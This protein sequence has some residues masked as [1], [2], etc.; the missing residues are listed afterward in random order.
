MNLQAK[1]ILITGSARRIGRAL[2]MAVARAG[3]RV[4]IH[5][6]S[7]PEEAEAA[8]R[9]IEALGCQAG[10]LQHD[11]S[12]PSSAA[13][14]IHA[15]AELG[16]LHGLV[17]NAAIFEDRDW[18]NTTPQD[19][20]R[21]MDINLSSPFFLSQAFARHYL[22]HREPGETGRIVNILDWRALWPGADH[23]PYT[24]SKAGLVALTRSLAV[25]LAPDI[26]VNG[27]ALGAILPPSTGKTPPDLLEH[28]PAGRWG[29][30]EEVG[31]AL[32]FLL[33][34]PA[35]ISG[36]ILYLDGGRHLV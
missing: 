34:G 18:Q 2:A 5:H 30:L 28:V 35:Y 9:E 26:C 32:V 23:L 4:I 6:R 24:I 25:S 14:L 19:W 1:T 8:R 17:N 13:E 33:G 31:Q 36:E 16:P 27:I 15:A 29:T 7:S 11:L 20:Q 10:V 22:E 12:D 21:H 3:G